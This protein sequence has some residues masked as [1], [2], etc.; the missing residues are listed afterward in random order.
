G[1]HY[2]LPLCVEPTPT[3]SAPLPASAVPVTL[4]EPDAAIQA[5]WQDTQTRYQFLKGDRE[6]PI[7]PP[8]ALL[9]RDEEFFLSIKPFARLALSPSQPHP[10]IAKPP[11]VAVQRQAQDP[12]GRPRALIEGSEA[13]HVLLC[14]DAAGRRETL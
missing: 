12:L 2:C 8:E 4:G 5:V 14:A 3:L 11:D 7:L 10:E 1:T 6:R 13:Q 9:L